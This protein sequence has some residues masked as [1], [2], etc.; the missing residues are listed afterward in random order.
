M[1]WKAWSI[2]P[3]L[4][5]SLPSGLEQS[6]R[7]CSLSD[8][9]LPDCLKCCPSRAPVVLKAQQEPHWPWRPQSR[10][11]WLQTTDTWRGA[12]AP[13]APTPSSPRS[14]WA[15]RTGFSLQGGNVQNVRSARGGGGGVWKGQITKTRHERPSYHSAKRPLQFSR[16]K[17]NLKQITQ[18]ALSLLLCMHVHGYPLVIIGDACPYLVFNG[19]DVAL[20]SPVDGTWGLQEVGLH[21]Q[22]ST[23][24]PLWLELVAIHD[25]PE[26]LVS[27]QED[28][29]QH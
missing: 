5:P 7:F 29:S 8:T 2:R 27:L 4:Q 6:T 16:V 15:G 25:L 12:S 3:P 23:E 21:E 22:G 1:Y 14:Y 17:H 13:P 28:K 10:G 20:F 26:L 19:G 9:N 24:F 11:E 18:P